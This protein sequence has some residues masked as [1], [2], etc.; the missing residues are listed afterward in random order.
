LGGLDRLFASALEKVI[1]KNLGEKTVERIKERLKEKYGLTVLSGIEEFQKIDIVLR[2]IFGAGADGLEKKFLESICEIQRSKSTGTWITIEDSA[3][4][5]VILES[6]GEEDK[7]K[8]LRVVSNK[9]KIISDILKECNIPQTS[10]YRKINALIKSGLLIADG[11]VIA[12]DGRKII[13]YLSLFDNT[14]IEILKDK[15]SVKVQFNNKK[16]NNSSIMQI[17]LNL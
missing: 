5:Q 14:K 16:L 8:V 11:E 7:V 13:K 1:T 4:N 12:D 2:E 15:I 9:S 3:I 6:Y 17:M 10:G